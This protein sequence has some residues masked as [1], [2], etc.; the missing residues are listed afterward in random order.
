MLF[1]AGGC[2]RKYDRVEDILQE[3]FRLR[4]DLYQKRKDYMEGLLEAESSKLNNQARFIMEKIQGDVII[5]KILHL[6]SYF[7]TA[8]TLQCPN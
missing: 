3:F 7:R 8:S 6:S 4:L 5:G 1:D 2:I